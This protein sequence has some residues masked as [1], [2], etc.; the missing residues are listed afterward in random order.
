LAHGGRPDEIDSDDFR[1]IEI[2]LNDGYIGNKAIVIA[3][4]CLTTGNLNAKIKQGSIPYTMKDVLPSIHEYI[5]P[6]ES[7]ED[8]K[9]NVRSQLLS[10]M[11]SRPEANK[12]LK[13]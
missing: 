7:D 3:L 13:E 1:N 11:L 12:Y 4:S 5:I 9:E 10:F 6:P 8:K 2:L